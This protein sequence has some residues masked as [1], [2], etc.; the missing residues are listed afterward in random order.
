ME[1][2]LNCCRPGQWTALPVGLSRFPRESQ[3]A[4]T[5]LEKSVLRNQRGVVC[6][7]FGVAGCGVERVEARARS[8]GIKL[9]EPPL[10]RGVGHCT[11][12]PTDAQL[13]L[14]QSRQTHATAARNAQNNNGGHHVA[15]GYV[16]V[17]TEPVPRA[18]GG[19][20]QETIVTYSQ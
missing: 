16:S 17:H 11:T 20:M 13:P 6:R 18:R 4:K 9:L 1:L 3:T 12:T 5:L 10:W 2:E 7:A 14:T 19:Y 15:N 8:H